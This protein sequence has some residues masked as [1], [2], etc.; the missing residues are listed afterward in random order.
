EALMPAHPG[1]DTLITIDRHGASGQPALTGLALDVVFP[2]L[3]G[4][5]GEDGTVQGLLARNSFRFT[6]SFYSALHHYF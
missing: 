4:P 6:F 1:G 2:V 5:H 3:H